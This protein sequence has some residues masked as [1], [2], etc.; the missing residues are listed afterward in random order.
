M[1]FSC[2]TDGIVNLFDRCT[3]TQEL[4]DAYVALVRAELGYEL[5]YEIDLTSHI[6]VASIIAVEQIEINEL[7]L[8]SFQS[9]CTDEQTS[10]KNAQFYAHTSEMPKTLADRCKHHKLFSAIIFPAVD[11]LEL[12]M[13]LC[14]Y[15]PG[16][17][18]PFGESQ[19]EK[20][21]LVSRIAA[22]R[23]SR[24]QLTKKTDSIFVGLHNLG[25]RMLEL[26][27]QAKVNDI[28][29]EIVV[30]AQSI[31][32]TTMLAIF[33]IEPKT[34][35]VESVKS[36]D[37][38]HTLVDAFED[39]FW[40]TISERS[41]SGAVAHIISEKSG[42][43]S[44][45]LIKQENIHG[46]ITAPIYSESGMNGTLAAFYDKLPNDNGLT[47]HLTE[48]IA[49]YASIAM[50]FSYA[51]EQS[52]WL[53]DDLAGSTLEFFTQ[54]SE[55]ALTGL[56]N[57]RQ[58]QQT[59][60]QLCKNSNRRGQFSF[61]MADVDYFKNY[62]DTY[63]HL[64]GDHVLRKVAS[65]LVSQVRDTDLVTRYGGEEFGVILRGLGQKKAKQI[66]ERIRVAVEQLEFNCGD[67]T[68]SLGVST[69]PED[70]QTPHELVKRADQALYKAKSSGRNRVI[71]WQDINIE[72]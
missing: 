31:L 15:L 70:A 13:V 32:S 37:T 25:K 7:N 3:N 12:K 47:V 59:L 49:H 10:Y 48:N 22:M 43:S 39:S 50:S 6:G 36:V 2:K 40:R 45:H 27:P 23:L 28:A 44:L 41:F 52:H 60:S 42:D 19:I 21:A 56:S 20:I 11:N 18:N 65:V 38:T 61:I 9:S 17:T 33:V 4:L 29:N 34:G 55:D 51:L 16:N 64:E 69:F 30:S 58:L 46:I 67:I 57:H 5:T 72:D 8:E 53:L 24:I 1:N 63:G 26:G 62:N 14:V 68:M 66:A 71:T 35:S 54:A